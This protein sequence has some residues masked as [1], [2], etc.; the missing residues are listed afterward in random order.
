MHDSSP[1]R[2]NLIVASLAFIIFF[3]AGGEVTDNTIRVQFINV[4]FTR[5]HVLA[6][7]AWALLCWFAYRYWLTHTGLF[8]E[9]FDKEIRFWSSRKFVREYIA[10]RVGKP[11]VVDSAEG[12]HISGIYLIG[13][14]LVANVLYA[15][16]IGRDK[17]TY[18]PN[19]W[20]GQ[21]GI[22]PGQIPFDGVRGFTTKLR[23]F[24]ECFLAKPSFSSYI[25]PNVLFV[26]AIT[27]GVANEL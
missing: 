8:L 27:L 10:K 5:S 14:K 22:E 18:E 7:F 3:L 11:V 19:M 4:H 26:A 16:K 13:L 17:K 12:V 9:A 21:E 15:K 2:R 25:V 23:I 20:D 1:E 24:I 6:V